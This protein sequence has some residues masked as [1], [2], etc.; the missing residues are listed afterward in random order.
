MLRH[1]TTPPMWCH[2]VYL[3]SNIKRAIHSQLSWAIIAWDVIP[4]GKTEYT[5]QF[6]QA[7]AQASEL[8]FPLV[9]HTQNC[10]VHSGNPTVPSVYLPTPRW[11]HLNA[12][13][14]SS[15]SFSR[16]ASHDIFL[17]KYHF[18]L[19]ILRFLFFFSDNITADVATKQQ[20]TALF[21]P[22]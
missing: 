7:I 14:V 15:N 4:D 12:T 19:H 21:Y 5:A 6:W 8:P 11:H 17:F 3:Q 22:P 20:T 13:S 18:L 2:V 1:T 10:A 16:R 9:F